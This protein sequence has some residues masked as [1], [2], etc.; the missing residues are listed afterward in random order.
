[1]GGECGQVINFKDITSALET[2]IKS[3]NT[4]NLDYLITRNKRQNTE[5]N[6]AVAGWVG[7]Y[8]DGV[9]YQPHSS[10][11]NPWLAEPKIR[12]EIQAASYKSEA[13]C[14]EKLEEITEFIMNAIESD[15]TIGGTVQMITEYDLD[16]DDNYSDLMQTSY[17]FLTL[18]ITAE[19][20]A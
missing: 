15:R 5:D 6:I 11:A 13:D 14:E 12:V 18:I 7:I 20:K 19:V 8:R 9:N 16:Y 2:Q 1:M 10:G 3:Y 17:Q 4:T